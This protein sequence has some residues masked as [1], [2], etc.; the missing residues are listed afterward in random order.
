MVQPH[1]VPHDLFR[2]AE[3]SHVI[4]L[5]RISAAVDV[6]PAGPVVVEEMRVG[7]VRDKIFAANE[8]LDMAVGFEILL[9][10]L[11]ESFQQQSVP[12]RDAAR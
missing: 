9:S 1:R 6:S 3:L 10:A 11:R 7:I 2:N 12:G 8:A 5:E 4:P